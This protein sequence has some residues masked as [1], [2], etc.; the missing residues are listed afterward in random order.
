MTTQRELEALAARSRCALC[1]ETPQVAW[2]EGKFK[3][4]CRC[5]PTSAP[6]LEKTPRSALSRY[7]AGEEP[8]DAI[9]K[10]V[11]DRIKLKRITRDA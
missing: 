8:Q 7:L 5:W 4:R 6:T 3:L 2:I 9:V 11:G 10:M 1:G